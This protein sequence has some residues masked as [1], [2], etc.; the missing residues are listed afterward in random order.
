[1]VDI[2]SL[3]SL[4]LLNDERPKLAVQAQ[5]LKIGWRLSVKF[6]V[7]IDCTPEEAR[8]LI[9]LPDVSSLHDIYLSKIATLMEQGVS[10]DMVET[11]IKNWM[12][13]GQNGM[14]LLRTVMSPFSNAQNRDTATP[15]DK[16]QKS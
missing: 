10:P 7:E 15:D 8:R 6:N 14:D 3:S 13:M 1:V 11:M 12:P 2:W 4:L 5:W 16:P 9:G